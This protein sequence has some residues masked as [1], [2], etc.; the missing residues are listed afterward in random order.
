MNSEAR[1]KYLIYI[2]CLFIASGCTSSY[3]QPD[4]E[5]AATLW[6]KIS[7]PVHGWPLMKIYKDGTTC[8]GGEIVNEYKANNNT[9][10]SAHNANINQPIPIKIPPKHNFTFAFY[11]NVGGHYPYCSI[12]LTFDSRRDREY[13]ATFNADTATCSASVVELNKDANG[14]LYSATVDSLRKRIDGKNAAYQAMYG[15]CVEES[16]K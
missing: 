4:G 15:E 5:N 9:M 6:V 8:L 16:I 1:Y 11:Q 12:K 14:K 2:F 7:K 3:V 10:K 13:L